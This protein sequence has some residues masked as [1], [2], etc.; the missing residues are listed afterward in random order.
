[1]ISAFGSRFVW[2]TER[3]QKGV[4]L[5]QPTNQPVDLSISIQVSL[6]SSQ[7]YTH[8]IFTHI[9]NRVLP[10][11]RTGRQSKLVGCAKA[12]VYTIHRSAGGFVM[13]EEIH[14]SL[15]DAYAGRFIPS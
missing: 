14:T 10:K 12:N 6:N 1:M 8:S 7:L 4:I 15:P 2:G 11:A 9:N 3:A 13:T 5:D